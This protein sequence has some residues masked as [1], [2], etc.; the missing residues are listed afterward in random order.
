MSAFVE[1]ITRRTETARYQPAG[2]RWRFVVSIT[3]RSDGW[4]GEVAA[5]DMEPVRS[6]RGGTCASVTEALALIIALELDRA[7]SATDEP[8]TARPGAL[9]RPRARRA[10]TRPVLGETNPLH[11]S[12]PVRRA[13][14]ITVGMGAGAVGVAGAAPATLL[15]ESVFGEIVAA[16]PF[17]PALRVVLSRATTGITALSSGTAR[18]VLTSGRLEASPGALGFGSVS[19]TGGASLE[20]GALHAEG[21]RGRGLREADAV[22][23]PW[24]EVGLVARAAWRFAR[25]LRLE[26]GGGASVP[27]TRRAF[28]FE[29]PHEVVYEPPLLV[30]RAGISLAG[31]LP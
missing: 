5:S 22:T 7:T 15:G 18:F 31:E 25:P 6:V 19:V 28:V 17:G 3:E 1:K 14:S 9:T 13:P 23:R 20:A 27:L 8:E 16:P 12:A 10:L 2:A 26:L 4:Q 29:N 21:I 24:L 30:G 11:D